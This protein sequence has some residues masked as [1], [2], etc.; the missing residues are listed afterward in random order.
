M[1]GSV[2]STF[3][4]PEEFQAAMSAASGIRFLFTGNG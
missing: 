4:D 2:T 1:R 3:S